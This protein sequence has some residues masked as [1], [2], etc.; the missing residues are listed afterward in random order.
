LIEDVASVVDDQLG[1]DFIGEFEAILYYHKW[2]ETFRREGAPVDRLT[3]FRKS[4]TQYGS[5]TYGSSFCK[6]LMAY[7]DSV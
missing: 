3:A 2:L 6:A 7:Y 5:D 4:L 1:R